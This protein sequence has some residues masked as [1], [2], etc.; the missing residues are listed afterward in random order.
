MKILKYSLYSCV[1]YGTEEEPKIEEV[2][3]PV[4]MKLMRKSLS[5]KHIM[6]N[7]LSKTMVQKNLQNQLNQIVLRHKL[8]IIP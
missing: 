8:L 6:V 2:L 1:N 7:I 5:V 3:T 4:G